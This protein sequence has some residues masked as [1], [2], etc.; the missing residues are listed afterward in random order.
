MQEDRKK[1]IDEE[2]MEINRIKDQMLLNKESLTKVESEI[3]ILRKQKT[4][5]SLKLKDLYFKKL[6]EGFKFFSNFFFYLF[7]LN[8]FILIKKKNS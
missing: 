5:I 1:A 8:K 2:L 3:R 4:Y 6:K 7:K